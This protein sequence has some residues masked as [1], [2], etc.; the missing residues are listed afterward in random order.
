M[1]DNTEAPGKQSFVPIEGMIE[2]PVIYFEVCPTLGNNGGL[3]NIMRATDLVEPA[4]DGQVRSRVKAVAHLRMTAGAAIGLRNTINNALLI[5]VPVENPEGKAI[6]RINAAPAMQRPRGFI[7]AASLGSQQ[8][9]QCRLSCR[10][11]P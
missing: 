11:F 6:N 5:G 4:A 2:A 9:C 10:R 8:E 1:A 7:A 3:M